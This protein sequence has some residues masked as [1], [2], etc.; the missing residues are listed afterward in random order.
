MP[1]AAVTCAGGPAAAAADAAEMFADGL[2]AAD[3]A[4][5]A[6]S[7]SQLQQAEKQVG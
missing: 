5:V 1:A 7:W 4:A 3:P 2:D 6:A